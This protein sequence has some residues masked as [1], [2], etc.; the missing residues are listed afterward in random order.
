MVFQISCLGSSCC[1]TKD[2]GV[3][4]SGGPV[5]SGHWFHIK[6]NDDAGFVRVEHG[7]M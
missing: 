7:G 5:K 3:S 2:F 1:D 6:Q 4:G